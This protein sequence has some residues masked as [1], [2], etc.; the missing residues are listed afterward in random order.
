MNATM[1][2]LKTCQTIEELL[3]GAGGMGSDSDKGPLQQRRAIIEEM[4]QADTR[5]AL[6]CQQQLADYEAT[7][8]KIM[9][10]Q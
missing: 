2:E 8:Q 9:S 5:Q 6:D 4:L 3:S 10:A 1:D 7:Y